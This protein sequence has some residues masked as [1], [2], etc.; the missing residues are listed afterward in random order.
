MLGSR[1]AK[2]DQHWLARCVTINYSQIC[3]V[4]HLTIDGDGED[5][6]EEVGL[7]LAAVAPAPGAAGLSRVQHGLQEPAARPPN[8]G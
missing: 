7:G 3:D 2:C 4:V 6:P 1:V 5:V 8:A